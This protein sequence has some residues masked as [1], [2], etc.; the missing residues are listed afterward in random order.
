MVVIK[1]AK[2]Q[3]RGI[4]NLGN[5]ANPVALAMLPR[6]PTYTLAKL[7]TLIFSNLFVHWQR[8]QPLALA[9]LPKLATDTLVKR[10]TLI[11]FY[12]YIVN[13]H[14]SEVGNLSF[15]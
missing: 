7:A 15:F 10:A 3:T 14:A 12:S 9:M 1:V 13:L 11:I 6:L 8:C 5:V 2:F 4:G